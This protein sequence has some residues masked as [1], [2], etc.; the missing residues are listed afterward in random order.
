MTTGE[1]KPSAT[2]L[3]DE[4][5][6]HLKSAVNSGQPRSGLVLYYDQWETVLAALRATPSKISPALAQR[7]CEIVNYE[8]WSGEIFRELQ[9]ELSAASPSA[10]ACKMGGGCAH[11]IKCKGQGHCE[12]AKPPFSE[13]DRL[14]QQGPQVVSPESPPTIGFNEFLGKV[15]G[16]LIEDGYDPPRWP[17]PTIRDCGDLEEAIDCCVKWCKARLDESRSARAMPH[18]HPVSERPEVKLG[19]EQLCWVAAKRESGKVYVYESW[20]VNRPV[21]EEENVEY[22][23][24]VQNEDGDALHCVGWHKMGANSSYD[25]FF[26]AEENVEQ[27]IA[28]MPVEKPAPP[29]CASA[30]DIRQ[31][32]DSDGR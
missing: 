18:W 21:S 16:K 30:V 4:I 14:H 11:S 26:M 10:I 1:D 2:R 3:A 27:I 9:A 7:I 28:W 32:G 29:E 25:E 31:S 8:G 15:Q 17:D 19:T 12:Y 23:W 22:G 13:A 24:E 6:S 5:E 20:W